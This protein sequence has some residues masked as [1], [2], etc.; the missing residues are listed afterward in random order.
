LIDLDELDPDPIRSF[1]TVFE[2]ARA[3]GVEYP[4]TMALA[5]AAADGRPSARMVLLKGADRRGF[6]FYTNYESRKGAELEANPRAALVLYWRELGVQVRVEG[7]VEKLS[8]AES[9]AYFATRPRGAQVS[10][11]VSPQSRRVARRGELEAAH[12]EAEERFADGEIP[13]P[14]HWG[15]YLVVPDA[16]EFWQHR[17]DRLHDRRRYTREGDAWRSERLAP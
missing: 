9:E 1:Q 17:D 3:A 12:A 14:P 11:W 16:I 13:L 5:T 7:T 6:A 8:G 10:A 15:G 4:E 2:L